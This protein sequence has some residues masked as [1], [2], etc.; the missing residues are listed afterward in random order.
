MP[1][2]RAVPTPLQLLASRASAVESL[3]RPVL[4]PL[5]V[6]CCDGTAATVGACADPSSD[7]DSILADKAARQGLASTNESE[8]RKHA[9]AKFPENGDLYSWYVC[10]AL[11][12]SPAR[13]SVKNSTPIIHDAVRPMVVVQHHAMPKVRYVVR[14]YNNSRTHSSRA[15]AIA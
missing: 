8:K 7:R 1:F 9:T 11:H 3:V 10:V 13:Y 15:C 4:Y 12:L 5:R 2:G 6:Q 14:Y